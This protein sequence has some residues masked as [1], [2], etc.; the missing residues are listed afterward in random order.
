MVGR[1]GLGYNL[2]SGNSEGSNTLSGT[3]FSM[4]FMQYFT[5]LRTM[6][7]M[8]ICRLLGHPYVVI[9]TLFDVILIH[10]STARLVEIQII[11]KFL[12]V[13]LFA[14]LTYTN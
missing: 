11:R 1:Y 3:R 2:L 9:T 14:L 5:A 10:F 13:S 4:A 12:F 6:S 7:I 8:S